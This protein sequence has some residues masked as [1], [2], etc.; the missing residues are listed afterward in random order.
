MPRQP[1]TRPR[2]LLVTERRAYVFRLKQAGA[3]YVDIARSIH[4][5]L[6][7]QGRLPRYYT[8]REVY[9][10]VKAE[11]QRQR[12]ELVELVDDVRQEE[13]MRLNKLQLAFWQRATGGDLHAAYFLLELMARR[14]KYWPGL[15]KP[16][17][18]EV[19]AGEGLAALL[20][21]MNPS[22]STRAQPDRDS[23]SAAPGLPAAP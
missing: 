19:G 2:D 3:T 7:W 13:L 4:A 16:V 10:D 1:K 23:P 15:E 17:V 18:V 11:L 9:R 5:D 22:G 21:E 20:K 12:T 14:A 8:E 6:S